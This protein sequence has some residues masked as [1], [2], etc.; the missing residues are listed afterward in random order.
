MSHPIAIICGTA[1]ALGFLHT[2]VGPDHYLPFIMLGRANRWSSRKLAA[3][4]ILCGVGHVL[5]SVALGL[6]GIA[7]GIALKRLELIESVR[8]EIASYALVGFG[9]VYMVWG[10]R[11]AR[12]NRPHEHT[13]IH[14]AG[15]PHEHTHTHHASHAHVHRV[16]AAN[17]LWWLF[18]IFVLGPCEPLIPLLMFPAAVSGW[19]GIALVSGVFGTATVTTM[20]TIVLLGHRGLM[21]YRSN[22]AERHVHALAGGAIAASG[23]AVKFLGL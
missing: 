12:K 4:T 9:L 7:V 15:E 22:W 16:Q 23:V 18:V 11:R 5:S 13:H 1:A 21:L 6:V 8:G 3:V 17:S 14:E 2:L 20:T 19:S 10:I